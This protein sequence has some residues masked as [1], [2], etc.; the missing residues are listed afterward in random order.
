M[1]V[2][3]AGAGPGT[4]HMVAGNHVPGF[5]SAG[6]LSHSDNGFAMITDDGLC[7]RHHTYG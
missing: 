1:C 3:I 7:V 5:F 4:M 2:G 6:M